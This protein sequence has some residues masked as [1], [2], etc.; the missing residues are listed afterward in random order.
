MA[1]SGDLGRTGSGIWARG[2][3]LGEVKQGVN[4]RRKW[5]ETEDEGKSSCD[6]LRVVMAVLLVVAVRLNSR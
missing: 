5:V 2:G 4:L 3:G 1:R 6:N